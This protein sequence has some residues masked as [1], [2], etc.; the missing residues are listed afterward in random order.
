MTV[1][2]KPPALIFA[3]PLAAHLLGARQ[4]R[5]ASGAFTLLLSILLTYLL[6]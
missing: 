1:A 3:V 4:V 6:L 5:A 2:T